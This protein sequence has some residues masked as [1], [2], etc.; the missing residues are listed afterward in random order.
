[1]A[2]ELK[3]NRTQ[4]DSADSTTGWTGGGDAASADDEIFYEGTGSISQNVNNSRR[5]MLFDLGAPTDVSGNHF[6]FLVNCG[7]VGALLS[8][9]AGGMCA[10]FTGADTADFI[11]FYI[12]GNDDWP[13]SFSGGWTLFVV[14]IEQTPSNTG[15]TPP[16]TDVIQ[17]V[18]LSHQTTAMIRTADN[19]WFDAIYRLPSNTPGIKIDG[20]NGGSTDWTW[21]DLLAESIASTWATVRPTAGGSIILSAPVQVGNNDT[22][23]HGLVDS[24]KTLLWDNQ[25]FM[26]DGFYGINI[27]GGSG[28]TTNVTAGTKTGTGSD[29]TGSQGWTIQAASSF[30]RWFLTAN[31][32]LTDS[33]NFYGSAFSHA[34]EIRLDNNN[35]ETISTLF[36]DCDPIIH[37]QASRSSTFLRN[38]VI[39]A[40]T[41]DG[42][43]GL[44]SVNLTNIQYSTFEFSDGHAIEI[45]TLPATA[46]FSLTSDTY[47]GYGANNTNDATIYNNSG[48]DVTLNITGGTVPTVRNGTS[49]STTVTAT[50]NVTVSNMKDFSEVRIYSSG[51]EIAGA[52]DVGSP[53]N[54]SGL[55]LNNGTVGG[56]TNARTFT[57]ATTP[58]SAI[59]IK[60]INTAFVDGAYWIADDISY[61]TTS[62]PSQGVQVAQ[63]KDRVYSN[64]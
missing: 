55:D 45:T 6:Y 3:D 53:T 35:L 27:V 42:Q 19:T 38:S 56:T 62:E 28:G 40:N 58:S 7:V 48:Q 22:V 59:V 37:S 8:K 33:I 61:T 49:A 25:E 39:A 46:V 2:N 44:Q 34:S 16:T 4:I 18:G 26:S 36:I 12:G 43:A 24:N 47:A 64:P 15:G 17:R 29:A 9:A 41:I 14:D 23:T 31:N 63:R 57:F 32:T 20:R 10:R 5:T 60:C 21:D 13:N 11:E 30:S 51:T 1:M 50:I 54:P 52:E